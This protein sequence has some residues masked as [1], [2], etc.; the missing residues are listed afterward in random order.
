MEITKHLNKTKENILDAFVIYVNPKKRINWNIKTGL[1]NK[2]IVN[3]LHQ[4]KIQKQE[5][6]YNKV[7]EFNNPIIELY[8]KDKFNKLKGIHEERTR[9][10]FSL[11][12][13][14]FEINLNKTRDAN[15]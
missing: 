13:Y 11:N 7:I 2:V 1:L 8:C 3:Y 6:N 15:S 14:S 5:Q 12:E 4:E 10:E 9:G